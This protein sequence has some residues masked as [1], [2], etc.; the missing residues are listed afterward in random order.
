MTF[1]ETTLPTGEA[2]GCPDAVGV[3]DGEIFTGEVAVLNFFRLD[4]PRE[5]MRYCMT[6]D[7]KTCFRAEFELANGLYGVCT[8]CGEWAVAPY[9]R[10]VEE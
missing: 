6:C 10:T 8:S 2:L 7:E 4:P 5:F 1:T 9:T 3:R